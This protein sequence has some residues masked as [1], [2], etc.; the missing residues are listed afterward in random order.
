MYSGNLHSDDDVPSANEDHSADYH[1]DVE[2]REALAVYFSPRTRRITGSNTAASQQRRAREADPRDG[3]C[4]I[5]NEC[6]PPCCIQ[7]CHILP[8]ATSNL[9]VSCFLCHLLAMH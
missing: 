7:V 4:M 3:R 8:K 5:S 2:H 6:D 1:P 9:T